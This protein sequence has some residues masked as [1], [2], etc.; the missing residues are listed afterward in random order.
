MQWSA[1]LA[2]A[3]LTQNAA[4]QNMLRFACSQLV[5]ERTDPLVN[6]GMKYTPHL[7]QIVGGDAF[8][9]SMDPSTD[10]AKSSTCTSCSFTQDKSNYWT[11]VM[12]FKA[13]NGTYIRVPQI[14]NGGPQGKLVND[15]GLDVY[16]IPSGKTTAF[17]KGF[18]M[19]VG[20]ATNTDSS[21]V[22]LANICHRCW[23]SPSESTFVGGVPC[24][25]SDTVAIPKDTKCKLIRQT[26]IFPACWNGKDLD[27]PDHQSHVA[28]GQ[29]SG[30]NGGGSCPSTHPV[31]LPQIMYEVM[32][33]VNKFA[34]KSLWPTDGSDPF[35][36]SMNIGGAAAHGDYVFGWEGDSLQKAMDNNCNLNTACP[37]AGLTVQQP[38]TYNACKKKQQAPEEVNGW[39]TEM[40]IG[41]MAK[42]A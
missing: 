16:Y 7:H 41:A 6:P 27:S 8:N 26:L 4:A 42:K 15:G 37:K 39:L 14:G 3:A 5:V 12:F 29:G 28:Y 32:W 9:I 19:L 34:D 38:A 17:K 24:S 2:A 23:T 1:L 10:L 18:R 35:V 36:Y 40:P 33:D 30:A 13:K 21:K 25:G 20:S 22:K 31:K 11:A